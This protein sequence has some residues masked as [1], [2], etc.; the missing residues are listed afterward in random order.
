MVA[1]TPISVKFGGMGF[2]LSGLEV[3]DKKVMFIWW[4]QASCEGPS[5]YMA[6]DHSYM[7]APTSITMKFVGSV[8][9]EWSWKY[10]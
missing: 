6:S 4:A 7:V 5:K 9:F 10:D 3:Y 2:P 1:P 8:F